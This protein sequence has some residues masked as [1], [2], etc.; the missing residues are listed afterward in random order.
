MKVV[1]GI[2]VYLVIDYMYIVSTP[3]LTHLTHLTSFSELIFMGKLC[4]GNLFCFFYPALM[5]MLCEPINI[6]INLRQ[7][8]SAHSETDLD[9][10]GFG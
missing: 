6:L 9:L 5:L 7:F 10:A 3:P 4:Y 2:I 1:G 8:G